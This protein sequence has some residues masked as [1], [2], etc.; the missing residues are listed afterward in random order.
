MKGSLKAGLNSILTF[1]LIESDSSAIKRQVRVQGSSSWQ[2]FFNYSLTPTIYSH[3][4]MFGFIYLFVSLD[5]LP[6]PL[7]FISVR[8]FN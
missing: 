6:F 3:D 2:E 4:L 7:D 8:T 5:F 1:K